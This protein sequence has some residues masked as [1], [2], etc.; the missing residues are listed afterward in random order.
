MLNQEKTQSELPVVQ[1]EAEQSVSS[2]TE[3]NPV[4]KENIEQVAPLPEGTVE[5]IERKSQEQTQYETQQ[6]NQFTPQK[7]PEGKNNIVLVPPGSLLDSNKYF[8]KDSNGEIRLEFEGPDTPDG[9]SLPGLKNT[10]KSSF[11]IPSGLKKQVKIQS[12]SSDHV[13]SSYD[14]SPLEPL[15][16][17]NE[18]DLS[19]SPRDSNET[20]EEKKDPEYNMTRKISSS[21]FK[22]IANLGQGAYA[23]VSLVQDKNGNKFALKA[24]DK[25]FMIKVIRYKTLNFKE[26]KSYQ[27]NVEKEVLSRLSHPNIIKLH[28]H[29][30]ELNKLYFLLEY[31]PGGE[32][33][34][35]LKLYSI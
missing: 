33:T 6:E 24:I 18:K 9:N 35:Y 13:L 22:K 34:D 32:F 12:L 4:P 23:E 19:F 16:P 3:P 7:E 14:G 21:D 31:V 11:S 28:L 17:V 1:S 27:V 2:N 20:T 26:G 15:S 25:N 29:F 5:V 10:S 8:V 30:Q